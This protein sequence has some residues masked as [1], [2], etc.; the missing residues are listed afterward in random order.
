MS[1]RFFFA[2]PV[3]VKHADDQRLRY[4]GRLIVQGAVAMPVRG[5]D[6]TIIAVVGAA[7]ADDRAI[8]TR[9]APTPPT[10]FGI[11]CPPVGRENFES[12]MTHTDQTV[13][14]LGNAT[15][16]VC[17]A[18]AGATRSS[19][20]HPTGHAFGIMSAASDRARRLNNL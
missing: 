15:S 10:R 4:L 16:T 3:R 14:R 12:D 8:R 9:R 1:K 5:P 6:K 13:G 17:F 2:V 18:K 19:A 11:A 7:F 20:W